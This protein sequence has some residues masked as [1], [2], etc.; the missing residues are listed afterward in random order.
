MHR[1]STLI[2]C[3]LFLLLLMGYVA[4]AEDLK[5]TDGSM[6]RQIRVLEVRPDALVVLH[7]NGVAMAD[8][9]KLPKSVRADYGLD[10]RKAA[11]YREHESAA[12]RAVTEENRRLIAAYEQRKIALVRARME[13]SEDKNSSFAGF[14][15]S[16]LTYRPGSD[17]AVDSAV[18]YISEE[19]DRAEQARIEEARKADTFWTAPFWKHPIVKLLG[20]FFG[21]GGAA[22]GFNSEPRNWH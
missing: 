8:F 3:S 9:E 20:A 12:R 6:L 1:R 16:E 2:R 18:E 15:N 17:R 21:G 4:D 7:R 5:L 22:G 10:A 19:I 13:A 11:A 14:Y